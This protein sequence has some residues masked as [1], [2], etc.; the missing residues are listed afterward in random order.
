MFWKIEKY[1]KFTNLPSEAALQKNRNSWQKKKCTHTERSFA[2]FWYCRLSYNN[3]CDLK[4]Y[5]SLLTRTKRRNSQKARLDFEEIVE[6]YLNFSMAEIKKSIPLID[7]ASNKRLC[8][9]RKRKL[10]DQF[11]FNYLLGKCSIN[12]EASRLSFPMTF[13]Q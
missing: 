12:K 4:K 11:T 1:K 8:V 2:V 13:K 9:W 7:V 3:Q 5:P 6:L 10:D